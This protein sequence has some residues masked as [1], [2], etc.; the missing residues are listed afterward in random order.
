[1]VQYTKIDANRCF[2]VKMECFE[3]VLGLE[4]GDF[5]SKNETREGMEGGMVEKRADGLGA[6][7]IVFIYVKYPPMPGLPFFSIFGGFS[8]ALVVPCLPPCLVLSIFLVFA[9]VPCLSCV[10]VCY[11]SGD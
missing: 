5:G 7:S 9:A 6:F 2:G 10:A 11:V 8:F 3:V 1:M 4:E